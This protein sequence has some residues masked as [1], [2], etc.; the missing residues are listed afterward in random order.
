MNKLLC[1]SCFCTGHEIKVWSIRQVDEGEITTIKLRKLSFPMLALYQ[2]IKPLLFA[3][4]M[5]NAWYQSLLIFILVLIFPF[6]TFWVSNSLVSLQP[7]HVPVS[8]EIKLRAINSPNNPRDQIFDCIS[9]LQIGV[10]N[11]LDNCWN[12]SFLL[13]FDFHN[14]KIPNILNCLI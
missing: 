12:L 4:Q 5:A 13:R 11:L 1:S 8:L 3:G 10:W 14:I 6:S 2:S 7:W 9:G